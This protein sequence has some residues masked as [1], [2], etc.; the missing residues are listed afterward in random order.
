[1]G[2]DDMRGFLAYTIGVASVAA[3]IP[4]PEYWPAA[5]AGIGLA[6]VLV[7]PEPNPRPD[8]GERS[9]EREA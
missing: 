2:H 3:L 9:R 1:M 6:W 4:W 7:I 5:V 8:G